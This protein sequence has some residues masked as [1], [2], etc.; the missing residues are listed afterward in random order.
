MSWTFEQLQRYE[1]PAYYTSLASIPSDGFDPSCPFV[2]TG[3][4]AWVVSRYLKDK[5]YPEPDDT[6]ARM[7]VFNHWS[8]EY[9]DFNYYFDTL[10]HTLPYSS[11]K[12][13]KAGLLPEDPPIKLHDNPQDMCVWYDK[14]YV[15]EGT[16]VT[17]WDKE[18][19][20]Y[21][22]EF[23]TPGTMFPRMCSANGKLWFTTQG[24]DGNDR[25]GIYFYDIAA[26]TWG[27]TAI[28][29]KKQVEMR[30]LI[31]GLDGKI[32]V[33][34]H[35]EHG[36]KRFDTVTG[37]YVD[38]HRINRHPY[39][40]S[41]NQSKEVFVY[42]SD[43][44]VSKLTQPGLVAS[45][46]CGT[47]GTVDTGFDDGQGYFWFLGLGASIL[48]VDKTTYDAKTT[49]GPNAGSDLNFSNFA[50]IKS[51]SESC[52]KGLVTPSITYEVWNGTGFDTVTVKPYLYFHNS[53]S[54]N[55]ARLSAL[56]RVNSVQV[57]GTAMISIGPQDYYG[58]VT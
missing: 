22:G 13:E 37:A 55:A 21:I 19:T 6:T 31:D 45:N 15:M 42:S 23:N 34:A 18:T 46:V 53:N 3:S 43:G 7:L 8:E 29:G 50:Y 44:M 48:R 30:D 1:Q 11:F 2:W 36:I 47:T 35:N 9:L 17:I 12:L 39:R 41:V 40:L 57:L 5:P 26:E 56:C 14:V 38:T 58:T 24:V 27:Y 25:Q 16:L 51:V 20:A 52:T 49:S 32:I 4:R 28:P 10:I 33:T 54:V